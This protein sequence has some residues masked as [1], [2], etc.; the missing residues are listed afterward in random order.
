MYISALASVLLLTGLASC[1]SLSR[2]FG[3]HIAWK[4]LDSGLASAKV[5]QKPVMVLIHRSRCPACHEL[6]PKFA[7]SK[8][9]TWIMILDNLV[10]C[11]SLSFFLWTTFNVTD[12]PAPMAQWHAGD[13]KLCPGRGGGIKCVIAVGCHKSHSKQWPVPASSI[14]LWNSLK[15]WYSQYYV[16]WLDRSRHGLRLCLSISIYIKHIGAID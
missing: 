8:V 15:L 11:I 12:Q 13:P 6:R 9:G 14:A 3:D 10:I 16:I 1:Q 5:S 7:A 2:G 4:S